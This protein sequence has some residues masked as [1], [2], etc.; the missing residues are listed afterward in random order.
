[1]KKVRTGILIVIV[2]KDLQLLQEKYSE[3][4]LLYQKAE[5]EITGINEI[6]KFAGKN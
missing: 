5:I 1:L 2:K 4:E 6:K 3:T